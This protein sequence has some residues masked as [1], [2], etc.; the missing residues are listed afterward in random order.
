MSEL[1][2]N[3]QRPLIGVTSYVEV[4]DWAGWPQRCALTP[5]AYLEPLNERGAATLVVPTGVGSTVV[6]AIVERLDGLVLIGGNDVCGSFYDRAETPDEHGAR[7]HRPVRDREEIDAALA[8][9]ALGIPLL[10]ICRGMQTLNVALGGTL[11]PDIA[12]VG[13]TDDHRGSD[14]TFFHHDITLVEGSR[15]S[16]IYGG[17][18][19]A[20]VPSHHHQAIDRVADNLAVTAVAAD[21]II[22]AVEGIDDVEVLGVQ[23]HPEE[24][25]DLTIFDAFLADVT[26][27]RTGHQGL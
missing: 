21:G 24:G 14:M 12:D 23:W 4:A 3:V 27:R 25:N 9:V 1:E 7:L 17:S 11:L 26:V 22:E 5:T 6:D 18:G 2:P 8:A 20:S 10:G 19:T 13:G 15:I 16:T